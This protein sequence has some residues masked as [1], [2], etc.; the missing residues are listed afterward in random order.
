MK[1]AQHNPHMSYK[2]NDLQL[3]SN[4]SQFSTKLF[5]L[6]SNYPLHTTNLVYSS[7]TKTMPDQ[8]N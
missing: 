3:Y 5:Y 1:T 2:W 7:A 4:Y 8:N 6:K